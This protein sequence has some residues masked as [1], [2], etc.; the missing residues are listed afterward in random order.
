MPGDGLF[1]YRSL[2]EEQQRV[3]KY[4]KKAAGDGIGKRGGRLVLS[5]AGNF[6]PIVEKRVSTD[7][8]SKVTSIR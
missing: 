8:D 1:H 2:Q 3:S 7:G 5:E 4:A 6:K